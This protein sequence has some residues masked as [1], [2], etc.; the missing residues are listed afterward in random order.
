MLELLAPYLWTVVDVP[1]CK[2]LKPMNEQRGHL[3]SK[4]RKDL[5]AFSIPIVFKYF[6][7]AR[8]PFSVKQNPMWN[9]SIEKQR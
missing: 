9:L 6:P 3:S 8:D 5:T 1:P 7:V 2:V 4:N